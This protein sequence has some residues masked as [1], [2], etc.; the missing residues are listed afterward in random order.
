[1]TDIFSDTDN[2]S[3]HPQMIM[4]SVAVDHS[5]V[6]YYRLQPKN[7][8]CI[9]PDDLYNFVERSKRECCNGHLGRYIKI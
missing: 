4:N 3:Q 5:Y 9:R 6:K 1:M 7:M 2:R 8:W